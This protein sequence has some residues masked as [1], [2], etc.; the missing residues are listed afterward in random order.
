MGVMC[1][2]AYQV[3]K[4]RWG[5]G[6]NAA[7]IAF[8]STLSIYPEKKEHAEFLHEQEKRLGCICDGRG[9]PTDASLDV[10]V[11]SECLR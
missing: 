5:V 3:P 2:S 4:G 7:L 8:K 11:H 1:A 6:E 10:T 9:Q